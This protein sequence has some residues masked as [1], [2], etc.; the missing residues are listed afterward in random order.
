MPGVGSGL[1]ATR[2]LNKSAVDRTGRR[3]ARRSLRCCPWNRR[4]QH[5]WPRRSRRWQRH[6]SAPTRTGSRRRLP[7][8]NTASRTSS[9]AETRRSET[10]LLYSC[11]TIGPAATAEATRSHFRSSVAPPL[12][13]QPILH[14]PNWKAGRIHPAYL[15]LSTSLDHVHP[16][17]RGGSWNERSNLVTACWPCTSGKADFTLEELGWSLLDEADVRSDWDGLTGLY[18]TLKGLVCGRG[19]DKTDPDRRQSR[20]R[21]QTG[22]GWSG[23]VRLADATAPAA[24]AGRVQGPL[25]TR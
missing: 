8:L 15:L 11:A 12:A 19:Q 13:P 25:E 7:P 10:L 3:L 1:R 18:Q 21:N 14:P 24:R 17:A 6:R 5:A 22:C 4:I 20:R 2:E 16:R 9:H 23:G